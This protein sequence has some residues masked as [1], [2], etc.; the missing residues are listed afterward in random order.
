[1]ALIGLVIIKKFQLAASLHLPHINYYEEFLN[2]S[3]HALLTFS[4]SNMYNDTIASDK[5]ELDFQN[6]LIFH[7]VKIMKE[8]FG[9]DQEVNFDSKEVEK[10]AINY[11]KKTIYVCDLIT[12]LTIVR[13][14]NLNTLKKIQ[15]LA[16]DGR[17]VEFSN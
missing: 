4:N 5:S 7:R 3:K 16:D 6:L 10:R 1:M 13:R 15:A 2:R 12:E 17:H 11:V 9:P 14:S 8:V